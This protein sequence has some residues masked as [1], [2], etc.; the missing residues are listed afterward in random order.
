MLKLKCE[1]CGIEYEKPDDFKKWNEEHS[2]VFFRWSL[3]YCDTCR[4][5]KEL[6]A[7]KEGLPIVIE[8]LSKEK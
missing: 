8:A 5:A 4:R 6:S 1:T 2:N 3:K 7:L